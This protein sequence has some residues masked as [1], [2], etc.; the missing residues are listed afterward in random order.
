MALV[1]LKA[2]FTTITLALALVELATMGQV[3]GYV[4]L[5][6]L[7][8]RTLVRVH[9]WAGVAL[10]IFA[11]IVMVLCLYAIFGLGYNLGFSRIKVHAPLG[12][13]MAVILVAKVLASNGHRRYLRYALKAGLL[14]FGL[15]VGTFVFSALWFYLGLA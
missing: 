7:P 13:A 12:A 15:A 3:R 1:E 6:N 4:R 9:R 5:V 8:P 10:T 11:L 14:A 2:L